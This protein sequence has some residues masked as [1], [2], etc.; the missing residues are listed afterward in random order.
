MKFKFSADDVIAEKRTT[1]GNINLIKRWL[2]AADE[3]YVPSKLSDEFIV[4]FLLSCNNDIDVTKKTITAYYKLRKDAPELFDDRT[5][6]REDIQKALNT[7]RMVSIPNRTDEN[8]QVVYLS[9]KDTDSSNFELNPVMKASLML[10]DIE[11]HNSPPDGVMFLADM[12]GFGFLHAFKLNP[13]SLKKYFNYLGEGIPTQFKGMHLMNGNYFVDQLLSILKV[14][15]ASDLIK[16]VIIHQVGWNPEE[17]FPKKCLPKELGGDLESEDVLCE[18]TLPL[19]K[20]R[21]YFWKAE[22]ELRKSVL[23]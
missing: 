2:F 17:A 14:F 6:E 23:K 5:S 20:D 16:R 19:F 11:H 10:I 21:E 7:L 18:R 15:M 12:K 22:E 3:K 13:I 1:Q 8:Y 4:L 9:L